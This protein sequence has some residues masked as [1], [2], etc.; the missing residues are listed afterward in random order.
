MF[1]DVFWRL[2]CF[3]MFSGEPGNAQYCADCSC[4][5]RVITIIKITTVIITITITITIYITIYITIICSMMI[6]LFYPPP[7]LPYH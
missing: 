3:L 2:Q 7:H 1:S 6:L 4:L 5:L